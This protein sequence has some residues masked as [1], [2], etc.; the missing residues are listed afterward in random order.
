MEQIKK[1]KI[2]FKRK[3]TNGVR[4]DASA[5]DKSRTQYLYSSLL[6]QRHNHKV[7]L[8]KAHL[9]NGHTH[10]ISF[11][12]YHVYQGRLCS[13][14]C[15]GPVGSKVDLVIGLPQALSLVKFTM[16]KNCFAALT[17]TRPGIS[18]TVC[19]RGKFNDPRSQSL[20]VRTGT[21]LVY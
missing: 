2:K 20:A 11:Q 5:R 15:L 7:L 4:G 6:L 18:A 8:N 1:G 19:T 17:K 9:P 14:K 21:L 3:K 12:E 13:I 16:L 10:C